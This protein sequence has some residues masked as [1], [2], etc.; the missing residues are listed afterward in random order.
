MMEDLQRATAEEQI[1][2]IAR[3]RD[4]IGFAMLEYNMAIVNFMKAFQGERRRRKLWDTK[5]GFQATMLHEGCHP[6]HSYNTL[7]SIYYKI[8]KLKEQNN[9]N[10]EAAV[11]YYT[12]GEKPNPI[13]FYHNKDY[14]DR[15]VPHLGKRPA[16][17]ISLKDAQKY[18]KHCSTRKGRVAPTDI[19]GLKEIFLKLAKKYQGLL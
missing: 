9:L 15:G 5:A 16:T 1:D 6:S 11:M 18:S 3:T 8:K 12:W 13:D 10:W 19:D 4:N 14:I 2:E 7:K 17:R